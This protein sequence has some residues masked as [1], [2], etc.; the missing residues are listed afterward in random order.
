MGSEPL[1]LG[2]DTS[3][4]HCAAVL[5]TG[6][7]VLVAR[8]EEMRR[9]Q[10]ERLMPL[11]E[12]VLAEGGARWR[13]LDR[14]GVGIGPG[15]FTGIRISVA[16]AR[17]LALSLE[18]SSIGI[19]TFDVIRAR[20]VGGTP[21]V[22]APRDMAHVLVSGAG[23]ALIPAADVVAPAWPPPPAELAQ[24]I[25]MLAQTAPA[26]APPPAPLYVRPADAAPA[27]DA[28]PVILDDA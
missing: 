9:G 1:V 2:F 28:P 13:D 24:T 8:A 20:S 6:E 12:E 16:A 18:I 15:N 11:L 21:A 14:I 10:A 3:A 4:A 17:G 23:P 27:R 19:S 5:L 25:A 22:P 7:R 26:D